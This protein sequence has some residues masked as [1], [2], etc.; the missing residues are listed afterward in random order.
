M[1]TPFEDQVLINLEKYLIEEAKYNKDY[2]QMVKENQGSHEVAKVFSAISQ[3]SV[4]FLAETLNKLTSQQTLKFDLINRYVL[5]LKYKSLTDVAVIINDVD[6]LRIEYQLNESNLTKESITNFIELTSHLDSQ[7]DF[8][9][10]NHFGYYGSLPKFYG[11][12]ISLSADLLLRKLT[13]N[14][15]SMAGFIEKFNLTIEELDP[16]T[17]KT[18][19]QTNRSIGIS[20]SDAII[21]FILMVDEVM[22]SEELLQ[23]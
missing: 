5:I 10:D 20:E 13:L 15:E 11:N 8:L 12:G 6:H 2:S 14:K 23:K 7:F 17:G 3:N 9:L 22:D 21:N 1:A 4:T 16:D 19:I 18:R